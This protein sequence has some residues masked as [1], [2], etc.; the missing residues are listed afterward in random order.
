MKC[1][2][3]LWLVLSLLVAG[4][5]CGCRNEAKEISNYRYLLASQTEEWNKALEGC[6]Q[7][8][9]DL[10]QFRIVGGYIGERTRLRVEQEYSGSNK[11]E[12]LN[13]LNELSAEYQTNIISRMYATEQ[14]VF[15]NPGVT[16]E[17]LSDAFLAMN[18]RYQ[19]I[20]EMTK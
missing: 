15:L 14:G 17:S 2:V 10:R 7:G 6:R 3:R 8:K 18:D 12:V 19:K 13:L 16:P 1:S 4:L 11:P 9:P 5:A 20:V